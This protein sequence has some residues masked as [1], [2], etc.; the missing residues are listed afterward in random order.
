MLRIHTTFYRLTDFMYSVLYLQ[1]KHTPFL[2]CFRFP[3]TVN[4]RLVSR[5]HRGSWPE[6]SV[7]A[8]EGGGRRQRGRGVLTIRVFRVSHSKHSWHVR[9]MALPLV[10]SS[11]VHSRAL[12]YQDACVMLANGATTMG[13]G[14]THQSDN[15]NQQRRTWVL[16]HQGRSPRWHPP[17]CQL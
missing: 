14:H 2:G 7:I 3:S 1:C 6:N 13:H 4:S 16:Q 8:T 5:V 11:W 12:W 17:I 10:F 9:G 15:Y